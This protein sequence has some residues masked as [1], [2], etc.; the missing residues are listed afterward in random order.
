MQPPNNTNKWVINL[1]ITPLPKPRSLCY[2]RTQLCGAP[3]ASHL[4][5]ITPIVSACQKLENQEAEELRANVNR[6]LRSAH[7][8]K[9]NLTKEEIKS[10]GKL[11]R[12]SN[13][14]I[15][16]VGKGVAM[17][18]MDK[19]DYIEKANS[20]LVQPAYRSIDRDPSI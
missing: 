3:Q 12:D 1:S 13:S 20:S 9:S 10:L 7:A 19:E 8:P 18:V 14:T 17:V 4:E 11:R 15:L 2:Q 5:Y 16:I 6:I